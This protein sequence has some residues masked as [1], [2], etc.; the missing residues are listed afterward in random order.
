MKTDNAMQLKAKI[1]NKARDLKIP[2]QIMLQNYLNLP[3]IFTP[4]AI[5]IIS[6]I[7]FQIN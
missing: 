3:F 5:L 7:S 4:H 1:N 2:A 6:Y